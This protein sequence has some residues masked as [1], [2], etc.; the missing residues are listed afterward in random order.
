M[1]F[2]EQLNRAFETLT[3]RLRGEIDQHVQRISAEL[4]AAAPSDRDPAV[5]DAAREELAR[6]VEAARQ[7]AHEAGLAAGGDAV[8]EEARRELADVREDADRELASAREE[9]D[10]ELAH[11]REEA[12]RELAA[13]E[14]RR[15]LAAV[16]APSPSDADLAR[17]AD[18]MR[19]IDAARSLTEMLD[20][21]VTVASC[22]ASGVE[23]WLVRG[24]Q[25]HR[26]AVE[27][28]RRR[29]AA[30]PSI[31]RCR[32]RDRGSGRGPMRQRATR[33]C[34]RCRSPLPDRSSRSSAPTGHR[35]ANREP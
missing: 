13:V 23:V 26:W 22:D 14:A 10:R 21:L 7:E 12:R 4:V 29:S 35:T 20:T 9:A 6:A 8:R 31:A 25:L 18:S 2:E 1:T 32:R 28:S 33:T 17:L 15:E 30:V 16:I 19:A 34:W 11:V 27:G 5:L 24:G 3:E